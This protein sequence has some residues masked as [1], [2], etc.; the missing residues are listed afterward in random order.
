MSVLCSPVNDNKPAIISVVSIGLTP[1]MLKKLE[2]SPI[3]IG[4][5]DHILNNCVHQALECLPLDST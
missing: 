1:K 5:P 2:N 3:V 4:C